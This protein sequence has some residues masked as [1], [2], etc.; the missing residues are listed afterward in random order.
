MGL[1]AADVR[2]APPPPRHSTRRVARVVAAVTMIVALA[3]GA[4][5]V[6]RNVMRPGPPTPECVTTAGTERFTVDLDQAANAAT[7][8][9]VGKAR[10]LPDHAVTVALA[11]ALQESNL[12][13]LS[14]G[15]RDSLGLFQQR[16]SQGWGTPEQLTTP[17]YAAEAFYKELAKVPNWGS[18]AVTDAA[19]RV[20][21]SG[22]PSAYAKWEPEARALAIALTGERPATFACTF[23]APKTATPAPNYAPALQRDLGLSSLA[24]ATTPATAWTAASWLI[25]HAR[26]YGITGV[27]LRGQRW[28]AASGRWKPNSDAA[29]PYP[30]VET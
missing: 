13:N 21:R 4:V 12:H 15:D 22:A 16:P 14:Y 27:A 8:A 24:A 23:R 11:A 26:E 20:Q 17:S 5:V 9:A 2:R 3:V 1:T 18:L 30:V 6:L 28:T 10:G 19:Q 25:A 7:I 29:S